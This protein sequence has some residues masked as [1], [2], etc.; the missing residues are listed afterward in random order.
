MTEPTPRKRGATFSL[1]FLLA[2]AIFTSVLSG[3]SL[4][5]RQSFEVIKYEPPE[6]V[7]QLYDVYIAEYGWPYV[8]YEQSVTVPFDKQAQQTPSPP[9]M[10]YS[11]L[12][13]NVLVCAV[14]AF[15]ACLGWAG[16]LKRE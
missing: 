2:W 4:S 10:H 14:M 6:G 16:V 5:D 9:R 3:F 12:A 1:R 13:I 7:I 15:G 8:A 11:G